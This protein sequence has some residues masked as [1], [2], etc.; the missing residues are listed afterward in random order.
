MF[1]LTQEERHVILF[2]LTLALAGIGIRFYLK[3]NCQVRFIATFDENLA[4]LDL[5]KAD[6]SALMSVSGIG[7]RIAARILE[8][9]EEHGGFS[10][11]D[12]LRNIK[13]IT[14]HTYAKIKDSFFIE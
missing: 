10:K 4:K 7:E 1:N 11:V 2:L 9:R 3:N 6:K 12:E 8:Y 14:E 5:N 13:G